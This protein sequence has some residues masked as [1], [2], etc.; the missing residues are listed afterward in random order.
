MAEVEFD[1]DLEVG[2]RLDLSNSNKRKSIPSGKNSIRKCPELSKYEIF[3]GNPTP[4][5]VT[6]VP[7]VGG[8][9]GDGDEK[10]GE[11]RNLVRNEIGT[12]LWRIFR[13]KE[14]HFILEITR[15][16]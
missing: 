13:A 10:A 7:R 12:R 9:G 6:R 11:G 8:E 2:F 16:H 15:S 5:Y 1:V 4:F 3:F 14:F